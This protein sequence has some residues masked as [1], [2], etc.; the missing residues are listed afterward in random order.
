METMDG[1][2]LLGRDVEIELAQET[3]SVNEGMKHPSPVK[4]MTVTRRTSRF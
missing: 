3:S 1:M 4:H 2:P